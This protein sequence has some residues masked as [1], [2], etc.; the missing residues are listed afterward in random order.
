[1]QYIVVVK[2][3]AGTVHYGPFNSKLAAEEWAKN[4]WMNYEIHTLNN[5]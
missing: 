1:M 3:H 2:H 5:V 4:N